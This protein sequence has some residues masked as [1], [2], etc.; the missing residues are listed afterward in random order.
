[1]ADALRDLRLLLSVEPHNS[2]AV[3]AARRLAA[4]IQAEMADPARA[5]AD[6]LRVLGD[7]RGGAASAG[8]AGGS[9]AA[10]AGGSKPAGAGGGPTNNR[11]RFAWLEG[12][13]AGSGEVGVEFMRS[14]GVGAVL[15]VAA[16]DP[17]ALS[18]LR[19]LLRHAPCTAALVL[20]VVPPKAALPSDAGVPAS[21]AA[22][23]PCAPSAPQPLF[24]EAGGGSGGSAG[25]AAPAPASAS[26][27]AASGAGVLGPGL[28]PHLR[29]LIL[30]GAP[31]VADGPTCSTAAAAVDLLS[32]VEGRVRGGTGESWAALAPAVLGYTLDT[33]RQLLVERVLVDVGYHGAPGAA[34]RDG[35]APVDRALDCMDVRQHGLLAVARM[36]AQHAVA[37]EACTRRVVHAV[38]QLCNCDHAAVR[39][40]GRRGRV[41]VCGT[42]AQWVGRGRAGRRAGGRARWRIGG[43]VGLARVC[44]CEDAG[45]GVAVFP[46]WPCAAALALARRALVLTAP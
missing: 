24:P 16:E 13:L 40:V 14:G 46:V 33:L 9:G 37:K 31:S 12:T 30:R 43:V 26:A 7:A 11:E 8:A 29:A 34:G 10:P 42:A 2:A 22:V 1:M 4:G 35:G 3:E 28:L 17:R 23:P 18:V 25:A 15:D 36:A 20:G 38:V 45:V 41:A 19:G 32:E 6:L 21:S 44:A 27:A 5:A 39:Q